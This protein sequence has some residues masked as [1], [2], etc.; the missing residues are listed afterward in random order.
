MVATSLVLALFGMLWDISLHIGEG[1]DE[2]PL[3]NPA[4]Y[5]ILV[6]LFLVFAAGMLADRPAAGRGP[7][8][9]QRADHPHLAR[10]GRR[11]A[12][13]RRRLLRAARLPARRRLAPAVRPGRHA[14]GSDPPDAHHRR[15]PVARRPARARAG[16]PRRDARRPGRV[17]ADRAGRRLGAAHQRAGRPAHRPVGLPGR[18]RLRRPAVPPRARADDGRRRRRLRA[19][20]RPAGRRPGSAIGAALFFLVLRGGITLLVGPVLGEPTPALPLYLGSARARR[21]AGPE[22][23]AAPTAAVRRRRRRAGRLGRVGQRGRLV[24]PRHAAAVDARRLGRGPAHGRRRRHRRR[25]VRRAARRSAC[26][27]GS[28]ARRSAAPCWSAAC[29]CSP[30]RRPTG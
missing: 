4:H 12:H 22:L 8:P 21:G 3:A 10:P 15:R 2:G 29:W 24:L 5:F 17:L 7:R 18:V 14:L 9:G 23:P 6:G 30:P 16:G 19:R 11:A 28:P 27:A 26:R 13:R 20:R 25:P 1:R